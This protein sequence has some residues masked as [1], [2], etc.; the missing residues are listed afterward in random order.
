[1]D[2]KDVIKSVIPTSEVTI[3][4]NRTIVTVSS[5]T[6]SV[7][8]VVFSIAHNYGVRNIQLSRRKE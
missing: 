1:M 6:D 2:F 8:S 4:E 5:I 7:E 3:K